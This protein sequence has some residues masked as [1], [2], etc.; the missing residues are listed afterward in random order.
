MSELDDLRPRPR[1]TSDDPSSAE[2]MEAPR[3]SLR[4]SAVFER[5]L[6]LRSRLRRSR[7]TE[8]EP[9][10]HRVSAEVKI[11][12]VTA[13]AS[14]PLAAS[15][16]HLPAMLGIVANTTL[17]LLNAAG[18]GLSIRAQLKR[19]VRDAEGEAEDEDRPES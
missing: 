11:S 15:A 17:A 13:T 8:K 14:V 18:V 16:D 10:R 7:R 5:K 4:E 2:L 6:T 12:A 19:T 1:R 9:K 3:M